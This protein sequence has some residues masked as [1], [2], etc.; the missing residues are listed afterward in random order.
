[1][2]GC[3]SKGNNQVHTRDKQR[4]RIPGLFMAGDAGGDVQFVIVA[5][6]EGARAA[7]AIN[8]ELQEEDRVESRAPPRPALASADDRG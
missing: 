6:A 8:R 1:M 7:A 4:T 2:L 5:A 3:E